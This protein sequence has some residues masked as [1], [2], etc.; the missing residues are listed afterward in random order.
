VVNRTGAV[1]WA[2]EQGMTRE[3]ED[4]GVA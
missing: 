1:R 2:H 4:P 3:V